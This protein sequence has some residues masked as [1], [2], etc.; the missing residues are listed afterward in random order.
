MIPPSSVKITLV[1]DV[2]LPAALI[3]RTV[4]LYG[5]IAP[6]EKE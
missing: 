5:I 2:P 3:A 6:I 4:T 1:V